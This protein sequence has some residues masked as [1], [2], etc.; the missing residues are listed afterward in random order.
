VDLGTA[1]TAYVEA[2]VASVEKNGPYIVLTK[3]V[4]LVHAQVDAGV[5]KEG[6]SLLR[7]ATPVVFGHPTNDPVDLIFAFS[8][9]G[10]DAHLAMIR[11]FGLALGGGLPARARVAEPDGL[12]DLLRTVAAD[13]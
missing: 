13:D 7:L 12:E 3:G 6:I 11:R 1:D 10:G 8:T 5:T 2:C 4:A 9:S